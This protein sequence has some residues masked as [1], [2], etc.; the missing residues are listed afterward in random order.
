MSTSRH[1]RLGANTSRSDAVVVAAGQADAHAL[2]LLV[3][4]GADQA[5]DRADQRVQRR[6]WDRTESSMISWEMNLPL[7]S[8]R[9]TVVCAGRMST[10][11]ITRSSFR[12]RK[13]GR[14]PRG[15]RPVGPSSTQCSWINC[16]TIRETVLR[17]RPDTRARSAREMG[18]RVR[19][20]F[21]TI[22]RL[23]SRTT[24]LDAPWICFPPVACHFSSPATYCTSF[25]APANAQIVRLSAGRLLPAHGHPE[26]ARLDDPPAIGLDGGKLPRRQC[27]AHR[28]AF[29]RAEGIR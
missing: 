3:P 1:F 17:C 14:R 11:M 20:R 4:A 5:L 2:D 6:P 15:R 10:A 29:A 28:L 21:R 9:A 25:G 8:A 16:S 18:W 7:A 19:M 22:R 23:M 24:S 27:E 13:V 26:C 12:R